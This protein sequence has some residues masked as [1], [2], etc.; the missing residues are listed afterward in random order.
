MLSECIEGLNINPDGVY[1]DLTFGGGGHSRAILDALSSK[2]VLIAFDQDPF[3]KQNIP[4]DERL[5]FIPQNFELLNDYVRF[6]GY[7]KVDGLLADFGVSSFQFDEGDRG[8]SIRFD[9]PLDMRM[10]PNKGQSALEFL[11]ASTWQN[12]SQVLREFGEIQNPKNIALALKDA[13]EGKEALSTNELIAYLQDKKLLPF[14]GQ[15]QFLAQIFQALRMKVNREVEV[16][17]N[18]LEKL[19]EVIKHSGRIVFLSYHSLEDRLVKNYLKTGNSEGEIKKDFYGNLLRAF[20][21]LK[22]KPVMASS[23]E[24]E[25]NPR[26]RS[27]KLRVG[28]RV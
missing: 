12:I 25:L 6:L 23:Q 15:K 14:K 9:G 21:P 1:V 7:D 28:E 19:E 27:A 11:K 3:A 13:V 4:D 5:K 16:I 8:F 17:E 20:K 22:S 18:M 10:N 2:G 26:S 24:V